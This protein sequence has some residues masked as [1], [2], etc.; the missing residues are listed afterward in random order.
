L[1]G[2]NAGLGFGVRG[3]IGIE[4]GFFC[5]LAVSHGSIHDPVS[6]YYFLIRDEIVHYVFGHRPPFVKRAPEKA[7]SGGDETAMNVYPGTDFVNNTWKKDVEAGVVNSQ[8]I[9][10]LQRLAT[11]PPGSVPLILCWI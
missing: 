8:L 5:G 10:P 3:G 2:A 9:E 11:V 4:V 7:R 1:G 6:K